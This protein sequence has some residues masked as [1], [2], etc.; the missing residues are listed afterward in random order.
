MAATGTSLWRAVGMSYLQYV[1]HSAN[2][3][4]NALKEPLKTK[5]VSRNTVDFAAWKWTNGERGARV[6]VNSIKKATEAFKKDAA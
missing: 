2:V 6:E 5:M 3:L 4:R 1:N